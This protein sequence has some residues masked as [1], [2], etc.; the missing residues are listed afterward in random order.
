M[1]VIRVTL[2]VPHSFFSQHIPNWP[3]DSGNDSRFLGYSFNLVV[4]PSAPYCHCDGQ[5]QFPVHICT[6]WLEHPETEAL[7]DFYKA[8]EGDGRVVVEPIRAQEHSLLALAEKEFDL[9]EFFCHGHTKLP[10]AL[11][12]PPTRYAACA[13]R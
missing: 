8:Y 1:V 13:T 4:R 3:M 9:V 12:A 7:R 6:A 2:N 11:Q 5:R 10:G